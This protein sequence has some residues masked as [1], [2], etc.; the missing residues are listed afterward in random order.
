MKSLS[1]PLEARFQ[2]IQ[3]LHQGAAVTTYAAQQAEAPQSVVIKMLDLK[4][5][6]A[7]KALEL[8]EREVAVLQ[9]LEHAAIP[10]YIDAFE[11]QYA[12]QDYYCLLQQR[13]PG[14]TLQQL[15]DAQTRF[16]ET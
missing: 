13:V 1:T 5:I 9:G 8:F 7:W 14:Q 15:I 2:E 6:Q 12:G 10:E 11:A 4:K 16:A 3:L